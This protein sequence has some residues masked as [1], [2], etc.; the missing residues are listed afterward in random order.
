MKIYLI[1][2]EPSGDLLG[3]RFMKAMKT[4]LGDDV[5]FC[6]LGGDTMEEAGLK[7]LFDISDLAIM[8]LVEVIPSIPKVL[9]RIKETVNDIIEKKPDVI[10]TIDSWS[11]SSRVHKAI[12][13]LNLNIPQV[14]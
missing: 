9:R 3:S 8:G 14:H 4:K 13:K 6:G 2:G 1:A 7:S 11:F 12:R 10:I 5:E